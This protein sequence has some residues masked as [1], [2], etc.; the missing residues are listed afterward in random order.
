MSH[1]PLSTYLV[2]PNALHYALR[3]SSPQTTPHIIPL[4]A[5]WFLPNDPQRRT[6]R[7]SFL[8]RHI[9]HSR[10]FDIDAVADTTSPYPHMLPSAAAFA[11]AMGR[12]GIRRSD[13]V[14]VYDTPE[15]GIFSAP[16]VAWTLRVFGHGRVHVLD[17]FKTWVEMGLPV[18]QGEEG[19]W[20]EVEYGEAEMEGGRVV[21]F[22]EVR[23]K[24]KG[25]G[26]G[27]QVLDA[28]SRGRW[29]GKDP[30][31]RKGMGCGA[32]MITAFG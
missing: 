3:S 27:V 4:S 23:E 14:V 24:V 31:P 7:S 29:E 20:E 8:S 32:G 10:F 11:R 21:G 30:E 19:N 22:E 12:L 28:R 25:E 26:E 17:N 13:T 5:A 16:R 18:E 2:S 9:P 6:G 15:L 1:S